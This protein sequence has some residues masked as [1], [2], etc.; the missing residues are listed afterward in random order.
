MMHRAETHRIRGES[1]KQEYQG[2][3]RRR[4]H[5]RRDPSMNRTDGLFVLPPQEPQFD[6][7]IV[8]VLDLDET[9]VF[10]RRG[11]LYGRPGLNE[12][13]SMCKEAGIEVVVWTAGLKSYAQ[14]IVDNIDNCNAVTHC[15]YR[16]TKWFT[17]QAGYRKDLAALGR[18]LDKVL[19]IENTPDCI[20]G[21]QDNGILVPDYNGVVENDDT[22][23]M[24][25]DVIRGLVDSNMSVPQFVTST[26]MLRK[27]AIQTDLGDRI[28]VY[29]LSSALWNQG[30][31]R[32]NMDLARNMGL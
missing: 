9:L 10:A 5:R 11:P 30:N 3:A 31:P 20:R 17:G 13:F 28:N 15:I 23:Y 12:L 29:T 1:F 6:G 18:P 4:A 16:H 8:L 21:Y 27:T 26:P 22:L 24:L 25:M 7:K 32:V 2:Q 14:A 19:I